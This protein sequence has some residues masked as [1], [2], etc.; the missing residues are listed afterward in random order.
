M[1]SVTILG[2][3]ITHEDRHDVWP[4]AMVLPIAMDL[5]WTS[6]KPLAESDCLTDERHRNITFEGSL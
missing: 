2:G 4:I 6:A 5:M 3:G 1:V